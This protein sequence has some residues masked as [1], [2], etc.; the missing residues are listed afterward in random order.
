VFLAAIMV[1]SMIALPAA[2]AGGAAAQDVQEDNYDDLQGSSVWQG[3]EVEVGGFNDGADVQLRERID[4]DT[5]RLRDELTADGDG[6]VTFETEDR[7]EGDYFLRGDGTPGGADDGTNVSQTFEINEQSL[8]AEFDE[9]EVGDTGND[10]IVEFEFDSNRG[11]YEVN[12]SADGDLDV[13]DLTQIF[14]EEGDFEVLFDNENEDDDAI[15][16]AKD[17]ESGVQD[18]D[19]AELNFTDI[20]EGDYEFTFEVEDT[21][22]SA[23]DSITVTEGEEGELDVSS[24]DVFQGDI[25]EFVVE[26]DNTEEGLLAIGNADDDGYQANVSID[27]DGEDEVSV[28]F[29]TYSAGTGDDKDMI[30]VGDD[31]SD[32]DVELENI[33]DQLLRGGDR[34][35]DTGDYEVVVGAADADNPS[36]SDFYDV[37]DDPDSIATMTIND[38]TEIDATQWRAGEDVVDDLYEAV[39]DGEGAEFVGEGVE[40]NLVTETDMFA[41]N[42]GTTEAVTAT[43]RSIKSLLMASLVS[44]QTLV[45]KISVTST[46]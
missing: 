3:Q 8:T 16:I 44:S 24:V 6:N 46:W 45:A 28:F 9:E 2:F 36:D 34:I 21:T 17:G 31:D 30:V 43:I 12:V 14:T 4:S 10:A 18:I 32:A 26:F 35:L 20:D 25:V 15:T 23:N 7:D 41:V 1:L 19:D 33:D 27:S 5:T 40:N 11:T 13:E 39:D 29:N 42:D 38:R 37:V 22:A